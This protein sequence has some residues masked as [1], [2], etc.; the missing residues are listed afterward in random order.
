MA[1]AW[2]QC[3]WEALPAAT[4]TA[5]RQSTDAN[6]RRWV[7]GLQH[8]LPTDQGDYVV[9][10]APDAGVDRCPVVLA[11]PDAAPA[12]DRRPVSAPLAV[13]V[14]EADEGIV[15]ARQS[16]RTLK[17]QRRPS[18]PSTAHAEQP[19]ACPSSGARRQQ[20]R[21]EEARPTPAN[22]QMIVRG[23]P[24]HVNGGTDVAGGRWLARDLL[25]LPSQPVRLA[26]KSREDSVLRLRRAVQ[27][28][29]VE[30]AQALQESEREAQTRAAAP[31]SAEEEEA[32]LASAIRRS[33]QPVSSHRVLPRREVEAGSSVQHA[34]EVAAATTNAS[35]SMPPAVTEAEKARLLRQHEAQQLEAALAES[36]LEDERRRADVRCEEDTRLIGFIDS[37]REAGAHALR[38]AAEPVVAPARPA[39]R[40]MRTGRELALRVLEKQLVSPPSGSSAV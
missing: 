15:A 5:P 22:Q 35:A 10:A 14:P 38:T 24:A 2:P 39:S 29:D 7:I 9:L 36:L 18:V 19:A 16:P 32:Q 34:A 6:R 26:V 1:S 30:L 25:H 20:A 13:E 21:R 3:P 28:A 4:P 11:A 27:R 31:R 8:M 33:M 17:R 37:L 12:V 23:R 40:E